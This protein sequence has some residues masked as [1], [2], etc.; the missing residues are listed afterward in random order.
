METIEHIEFDL[1]TAKVGDTY[2]HLDIKK[3]YTAYA[4]NGLMYTIKT[5]SVITASKLKLIVVCDG[6]E[7][8]ARRDGYAGYMFPKPMS[9]QDTADYNKWVIESNA[10]DVQHKQN[11]EVIKSF[12][13]NALTDYEANEI[14]NVLRRWGK[15]K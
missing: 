6:I 7:Y 11:I 1:K 4:Y 10:A 15:V 13:F 9:V 8:N 5:V 12:D 14:V 2:R 3:V